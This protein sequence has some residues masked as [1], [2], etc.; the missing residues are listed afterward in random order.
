MRKYDFITGLVLLVF[1]VALMV[2]SGNM[3][4]LTINSG[5]PWYMSSGLFPLI[6]GGGL[7]LL[8][9]L[10]IKAA[11]GSVRELSWS[12]LRRDLIMSRAAKTFFFVTALSGLYI[13]AMKFSYPV[14]TALYIFILMNY[15]KK[16]LWRAALISV[17]ATAV[18][19]MLFGNLAKIPL[20]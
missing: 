11:A 6:I 8:A 12:G 13:A 9:L 5:R 20:P 14:A 7:F 19:T 18:I 17:A 4:K 2:A 10:L 1:S 15:V 3:L 16:S